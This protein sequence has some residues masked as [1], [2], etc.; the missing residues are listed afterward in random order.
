MKK[1]ADIIIEKRVFFLIAIIGLT[2]FFLYQ[3]ITGLTVK[4]IFDD[5][6]PTNHAYTRLHREIR[7]T[8]GG[9][10][11]VLIMVQV[12]DKIDGGA[13]ED[14]FNQETLN[15]V[16]GITEDCYLLQ[17]VD[18][19]KILS[20]ASS[21]VKNIKMS[22]MG[23]DFSSVMY[24]DVPKTQ[25]EIE[26]LRQTVYGNPICYPALVSLDSKKTMIM[27]DFF[28]DQLD[29]K[30]LFQ[31]LKV[32]RA[33]YENENLI[34]AIAGEPMHMG[35]LDSYVGDVLKILMY[36]IIAMMI[37][38]YIYFRS[39]RG[40]LLPILAAG[41]SA[42]WGLGFMGLLGFNLDP[43]V[44]VFPFLIAAMA[45]SHSVQVIKRYKEEAYH[46]GDVKQ[47][48]KSVIEHLFVPGFAGIIT[49]ASGIIVIA[50][51]PIPI[52]QK[53]CLSC[54]F[55]AFATVIIAMI[56]VPILL[57]YMPIK[58]VKEGDGFLDRLLKRTGRWIV[59]WGKYPVLAI[60]LTALTW[61]SFYV[62]DITIGNSVPGSEIL[63]P[64]HRYNVD[65]FRIT[66][67][68]PM[69]NPLYVVVEGEDSQAIAKPEV[70]R[71]IMNFQRYM[72]KTPDKRV[73]TSLSVLMQ[74]PGR[75]EAIRDNDMNWNFVPTNDQQLTMLFRSVIDTAGP[76]GWDKYI[77]DEDQKT[78][79]IIFCRDKTSETIKTVI[80]RVNSYIRD[81][82]LFG[83]RSQDI[84]RKGFDKFVYWLDGFFREQEPP[85]PEKP[86]IEGCP[87]V[88]YRLAG[89]AVGIQAGINEALTLYQIWTFVI[90]LLTVLVLCAFIFRSVFAGIIITLPLILSNVLAF[91]FMALNNPPLPLTTATLPVASVGIGLGVDYGIY[92]VSRIIE[93][94]ERTGSLE[95]AIS[96]AL[97]T[98]G[99]AIVYIA[100]TLVCGIVFWFL[101]TMMFQALM[102]L[103]LA[104]ILIFNMLGAL[105][106][107]PSCIALVQPKFVTRRH[108]KIQKGELV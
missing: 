35:Y 106:I 98:T 97:G 46:I 51:T 25:E 6:V 80:D 50:L 4:T 16:K 24:P 14:I 21:K 32:L 62:N 91:A 54:A 26:A 36:T 52:L 89:G 47:T 10:N 39:K 22:A 108:L 1:F 19:F 30:V 53:I 55:W 27:V 9:A 38:F 63:W 15:T 34:I 56:L 3:A 57:S 41:V 64:W 88:Y 58:T 86:E 48:C 102:G 75:N 69:L 18:R 33:K 84:E 73:M 71:D 66:F 99:K 100:T 7:G 95:T 12:R 60:S 44:L 92:L 70:I 11:Q 5:I 76:G 67:A 59:S 81:E 31:E 105:L 13:Y 104:I 82:S 28:E 23:M 85:I 45:A 96:Q 29:Y 49:D 74:I 72:S 101:S 107:I 77:D 79:I 93:E 83:K 42:I 8:F 103:L 2:L 94:F 90:A 78:N 87:K 65:S 68:M 37:V 40:M 20:L 61:G 17:G 43:L